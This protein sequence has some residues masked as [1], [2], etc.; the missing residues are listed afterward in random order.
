MIW[1]GIYVTSACFAVTAICTYNIVEYEDVDPA[2][3]LWW[4]LLLVKWAWKGLVAVWR[5]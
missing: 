2:I 3:G 1:L 4:P 5:L